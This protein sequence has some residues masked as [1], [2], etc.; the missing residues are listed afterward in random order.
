MMKDSVVTLLQLPQGLLVLAPQ[1]QL[2]TCGLNNDPNGSILTGPTA[3]DDIC[4]SS[5]RPRVSHDISITIKSRF[6]AL[7]GWVATTAVAP[8]LGTVRWLYE[9]VLMFDVCS[10][11]VT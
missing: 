4:I 2:L 11:C 7:L 5:I 10:Y 6:P 9:L 1:K 8:M 3:I